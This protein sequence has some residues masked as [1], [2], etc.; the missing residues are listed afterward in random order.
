MSIRIAAATARV[1]LVALLRRPGVVAVIV[2]LAAFPL[3][4]YHHL[5]DGSTT[6]I[7]VAQTYFM[8]TFAPVAIGVVLAD[9][10]VRD[11]LLGVQEVLDALPVG[12]APRLWGRFLG[13]VVGSALP[14]LAVWLVAAAHIA[15]IR[16]DSNALLLAAASF[17]GGVLPGLVVVCALS[18]LG[19]AV[20]GIALFRVVFVVYWFWGNLV[21]TQ[22]MPSPSATWFTPIGGITLS[23]VF[24]ADLGYPSLTVAD[25][26]ASI[27]VLT[28]TGAVLVVALQYLERRRR[29]AA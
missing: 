20:L 8:N 21:P 2:A 3:L 11:R 15:V 12:I 26:V 6:Q 4:T 23:A 5:Y 28:V 1:E 19:P 7:V 25:G 22:L 9:R 17:A 16:H 29:T 10:F 24:H 14:V 27:T 18:L 13:L